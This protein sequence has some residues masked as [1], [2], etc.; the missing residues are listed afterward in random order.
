MR[1]SEAASLLVVAAAFDQRTIGES[2][3]QAWSAALQGI[4]FTEARDAVV[5]HYRAETDRVKPAHVIRR[6]LTARRELRAD[7]RRIDPPRAMADMPQIEARWRQLVERAIAE[8]ESED[9][10]IQLACDYIG[11][12]YEPG[13]LEAV[14]SPD[15]RPAIEAI[16][17]AMKGRGDDSE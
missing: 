1:P 7:V 14:A 3:A 5:A 13:E 4:G 15:L 11:I 16:L 9:Q 17:H 2:D 8:G 6:V 12:R 10:A